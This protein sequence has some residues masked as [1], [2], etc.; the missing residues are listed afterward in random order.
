MKRRA[1]QPPR[2]PYTTPLRQPAPPP[3]ICFHR[4]DGHSSHGIPGHHPGVGKKQ[5][6]LSAQSMFDASVDTPDRHA[7]DGQR[8]R[9]GSCPDGGRGWTAHFHHGQRHPAVFQRRLDARHPAR[10]LA[11]ACGGGRACRG[12]EYGCR[13]AFVGDASRVTVTVGGQRRRTLYRRRM[14][15][16]RTP[17]AAGTALPCCGTTGLCAGRLTRQALLY[18]ALL[19]GGLALLG[20]VNWF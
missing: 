2:G 17:R 15:R 13:A 5:T 12:C 11:G 3:D 10:D 8:L 18:A 20:A 16:P 14:L 9:H 19:S 6:Q 7:A 4:A 1:A